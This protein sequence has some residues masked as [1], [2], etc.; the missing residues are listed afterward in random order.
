MSK[1]RI[2]DFDWTDLERRFA[3]AHGLRDYIVVNDEVAIQY[4]DAIEMRRRSDGV[5]TPKRRQRVSID[6]ETRSSNGFDQH[7][8]SGAEPYFA[9]VDECGP[10]PAA[11]FEPTDSRSVGSFESEIERIQT[12]TGRFKRRWPDRRGDRVERIRR[13]IRSIPYVAG[14]AAIELLRVVR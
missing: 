2:Y 6:I 10:V 11:L 9:I 13:T 4:D 14:V 3:E 5:W 1:R 12:I 7:T 8:V